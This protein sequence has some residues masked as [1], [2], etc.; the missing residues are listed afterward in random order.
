MRGLKQQL[1][2]IEAIR[3]LDTP[4]PAELR[5]RIERTIHQ[6]CTAAHDTCATDDSR[7]SSPMD[8]RDC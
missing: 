2:A 1:V 3:R 6:A 8:G 5:E 4:A 7:H